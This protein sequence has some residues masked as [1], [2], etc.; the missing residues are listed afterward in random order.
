M[1]SGR[2]AWFKLHRSGRSAKAQATCGSK[3]TMPECVMHP[4]LITHSIALHPAPR[5]CGGSASG[6]PEL[7]GLVDDAEADRGAS[8]GV[9]GVELAQGALHGAFAGQVRGDDDG[10]GLS[11]VVFPL[12]DGAQADAL[13][14]EDA[15]DLRHD[16]RLIEGGEAQVVAGSQLGERL[17]LCPRR[18]VGEDAELVEGCLVRPSATASRSATTA[19]AVGNRP[20]PRP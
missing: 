6:Q 15:R 20:A 19:E 2:W 3:L 18:G 16:A 11:L 8:D 13:I 5:L 9:K 7:L 4:S 10:D 1:R 12:E 14:A 17:D